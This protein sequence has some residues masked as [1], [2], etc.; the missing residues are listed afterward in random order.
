MCQACKVNVENVDA[1]S[2][3]FAGEMIETLNRATLAFGVSLGHRTGLFDAM[4]EIDDWVS[5]EALA[6]KASCQERYVR[7]WLG[8]MVTGGIVAYDS[9]NETYFLPKH[10]A[11]LLTRASGSGNIAATFQ[12]LQ[13]MGE[14]ESQIVDCFHNGGGVPYEA[15]SRFH[16]V[17]AE[18]SMGTVVE[19][20]FTQILPLVPDAQEKL[21]EGIDVLDI[22]CGSGRALCALA[23]RFPNSRFVGRDLCEAPIESARSEADRLGLKNIRFEVADIAVASDDKFDLITA[24]DVIHDQRAPDTVLK[25]V[26]S[27]L[28]P[29]G[30]FLMQDL[31]ASSKLEE[32]IGHLLCPFLYM[33]STMHCMTVSLAQ[34]GAGLGTVWGEQL[35]E[36]MLNEAGFKNVTIQ[37]LEHDIQNSWYV[38]RSDAALSA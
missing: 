13:M 38:A 24:F 17:M 37:N 8:A 5:S 32:N 19:G 3:A 9:D 34:D 7:E 16:T 10:H 22:G 2:E 33:I 15:F 1:A 14:V 31:K 29:G 30:T 20:L 23:E 26:N 28:R 27:M 18:E 21:E 11:A 6:K 4:A 36:R 12:F 35:A 25:N